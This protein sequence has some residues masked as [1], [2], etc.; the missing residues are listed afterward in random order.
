MPSWGRTRLTPHILNLGASCRQGVLPYAALNPVRKNPVNTKR[1]SPRRDLDNLGGKKSLYSTGAKPRIVYPIPKSLPPVPLVKPTRLVKHSLFR[2][3]QALGVV[4][5]GSQISRQPAHV[6]GNVVSPT[7]RP[8]LPP[9][10]IPG[11]DFC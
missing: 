8:P 7:H 9:G 6:G 1:V 3:R 2:P 11:T 10:N 5:L 4:G